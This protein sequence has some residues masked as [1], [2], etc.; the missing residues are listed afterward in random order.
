MT[1]HGNA[2][3]HGFMGKVSMMAGASTSSE[4]LQILLD[5]MTVCLENGDA[6]F[7]H[8]N[9]YWEDDLPDSWETLINETETLLAKTPKELDLLPR[10]LILLKKRFAEIGFLFERF[11]RGDTY[12]AA[13]KIWPNF[14]FEEYAVANSSDE[15]EDEDD[16]DNESEKEDAEVDS[17]M[18][19]KA[20]SI[21]DV[22]DAK[23][24]KV[25]G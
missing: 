23:R 16:D 13:H 19:R 3:C 21:D 2:H 5:I 14:G 10:D 15:D 18:K 12:A 20:D 8:D 7:I 17:S 22:V 1:R 11:D 4:K 9:E 25:I 24:S 6:F